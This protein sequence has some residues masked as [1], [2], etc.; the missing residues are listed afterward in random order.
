[1][2]DLDVQLAQAVLKVVNGPLLKEILYYQETQAKQSKLM[3]GRA[4]LWHIYQQYALSAAATHAI[5]LQTLMALRF[6]GD[7]EGFMRAFDFCFVSMSDVPS[8]E[9]FHALLDP[10]LRSCKLLKPAFVHLN[11]GAPL[12]SA[13]QLE[14]MYKAAYPEIEN[15]QRANT[16][17][18]LL[19]PQS[20][21]IAAAA[22]KAAQA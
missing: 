2:G 14:F 10:Q 18:D 17:Q 8:P 12:P 19:R 1:M 4:A 6:T 9:F 16:R 7:L 21:S 20:A 5:D 3:Q 22:L 13:E 11:G 15:W